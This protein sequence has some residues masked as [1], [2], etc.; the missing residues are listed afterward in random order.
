MNHKVETLLMRNLIDVFGERD[1]AKR[2]AAIA[3]LWALDGIF[4]DPH[5]RHVGYAALNDAVS[6]LHERFPGFVF[7][8]IGSPQTFFDVGRQA[9]GH[10]PIGKPPKVT[11][12]DVIIARRGRI[13]ALYAFID[14]PGA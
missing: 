4:A 5:G 12:I 9:W 8:P 7:T 2:R 10:G 1:R 6:K 13:A 14:T 3:E 11:G